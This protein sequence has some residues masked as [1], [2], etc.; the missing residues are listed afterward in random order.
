MAP[1]EQQGATKKGAMTSITTNRPLPGSVEASAT[2]IAFFMAGFG[3]AA[4]APMVPFA[5][6]R[7]AIQ[8]STLGTLLLCLG[9]GSILAMPLAGALASRLGCRRVMTVATLVMRVILPFL[10]QVSTAAWLGLMLFAFGA[11]VGSLDCVMNIQAVLVE[12]AGGQPMMSGFHGLYSLGA[13]VAAVSVSG[14]LSLGV[15]PG[16]AGLAVAAGIVLLLLLVSAPHLLPYGGS[17][18]WSGLRIATRLGDCDRRAL[19]HCVFDR[20]CHAGL[21]RGFSCRGARHVGRTCGAGLC[22][23][24]R[25]HDPESAQWRPPGAEG[26]PQGHGHWWLFVGSLLAACGLALATLMPSWQMALLGFAQVGVGCSNIVPIMF[27]LAGRQ[28]EMPESVAVAAITTMGYAGVLLGPALIGFV[29]ASS[30]LATALLIL[31]AMLLGVA[32]SVRMLKMFG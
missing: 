21:E 19:L 27:S 25:H 26:R 28:H 6:Q 1:C 7:L 29:S 5:K 4:W 31:A 14:L 9:A 3:T 15:S 23:I 8:D 32:S 10:T 30:S 24:C 17:K 12:R 16:Q 2:R 13:V 20:R 11:A 18:K 22:R